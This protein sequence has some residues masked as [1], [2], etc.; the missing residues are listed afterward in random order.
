MQ[1]ES[2]IDLFRSLQRALWQFGRLSDRA[3]FKVKAF[4]K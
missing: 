4:R 1:P 3:Q 2:G